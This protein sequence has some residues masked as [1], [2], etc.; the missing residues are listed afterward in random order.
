MLT[1]YDVD[2]VGGVAGRSGSSD[3]PSGLALDFMTTGATGDR[4]AEY[5]LAN[6]SEFGVTY[7]IW[8]QRYNDGSGWS[9]MED[10]GGTTANHYDH[11]HVSFE[12]YADV[13]VTC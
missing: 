7:V 10:R 3:H 1:K 2:S 6:Q 12:S 13:N 8:E 11:V 9:Y 4:I 5:V